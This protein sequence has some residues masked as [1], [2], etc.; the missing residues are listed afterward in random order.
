[1]KQAIFSLFLLLPAVL[2]SAA[3]PSAL[4]RE[5]LSAEAWFAGKNLTAKQKEALIASP[6][7]RTAI[8]R[9]DRA[10]NE[11]L[12]NPFPDL[13]LEFRKSG[14]R[15]RF[16][17]VNDRY[18]RAIAMLSTAWYATGKQPY[19]RKLEELLLKVCSFPTWVLPAHDKKL[20]NFTGKSIEID[21]ASSLM[22]WRLAT[23]LG[24]FRPDLS[25]AT[26]ERL[27]QEL[28]RRILIPFDRISTG[29]RAP[30]WWM[31][32]KMNWNAVCLA[33]ITGTVLA[34]ESDSEK[35]LRMIDTVLKY[36]RNFLE[37]FPP[38]GYCTEG[39]GYWNYGFGH[40]LYLSAMLYLATD[41]R[42]NL[43]EQR[44]T[45]A[46][47]AYPERIVIANGWLPAFADCN[48]KT[49]IARQYLDLRDLLLGRA[50][51]RAPLGW[52]PE[53]LLSAELSR[54]DAAE[55]PLSAPR[56]EVS[57]FPDGAV[58]VLRPGSSRSCRIAAAVKGGHN[59]ELHNHNDVGSYTV[60]ADGIPVAGDPGAEIYNAKT[61]GPERYRNPIMNS[62]GHPVPR[63]AGQLQSTGRESAARLLEEKKE[64]ATFFWKLDLTKAYRVP[65]MTAL[66]RSF[67]Y[68]RENG[69]SFTVTDTV[70]F[71]EPES[72]ETA[73]IAFGTFRRIAPNRLELEFSGSRVLV[74]IESGGEAFELSSVPI[75]GRYQGGLKPL[76]IAIRLKNAVRNA[77]IRLTFTPDGT[78]TKKTNTSEANTSKKNASTASAAASPRKQTDVPRS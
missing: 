68:S 42:I 51:K 20:L 17:A 13:Y 34:A 14:N 31:E 69:G 28:N 21:L 39:A 38:D 36:S 25:P 70:E 29:K 1:M 4:L 59:D 50:E 26:A 40:Y 66:E 30:F 55:T 3:D 18:I 46:P 43:L 62:F 33:G 72:F 60:V 49:R 8:R 67:F 27:Q 58:A 61:F 10:L 41:R 71:S 24:L 73:V 78:M 76:R 65:S 74:S 19:L 45:R 53:L 63:P 7:V 5:S 2:L 75:P 15:T 77:Q 22:G 9:A 23:V 35:R 32:R 37:S 57:V 64:T 47:A 16:Q 52:F 11:E 6:V 56:E 48:Y 54:T 12:P 44:A